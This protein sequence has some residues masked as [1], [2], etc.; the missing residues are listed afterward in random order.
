M[1]WGHFDGQG[2]PAST[3]AEVVERFTLSARGD[4]LD[5]TMVFTDPETFVEPMTLTKH[6]VWF[7]DAEVAIYDCSLDA[8]D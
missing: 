1:G 6:W 4:R 5:Y 8:E 2:I 7:P 3:M